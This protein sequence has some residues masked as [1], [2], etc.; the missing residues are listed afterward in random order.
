MLEHVLGR[1][2]W[3]DLHASDLVRYMAARVDLGNPEPIPQIQ[4]FLEL[5]QKKP[6]QDEA[7][8][9]LLRKMTPEARL[10]CADSL[11]IEDYGK[12]LELARKFKKESTSIQERTGY[13]DTEESNLTLSWWIKHEKEITEILELMGEATE[14]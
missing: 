10:P 4:R 13:T 7:V 3:N 5:A 2:L 9:H 14:L 8:L 11:D 1:R 6:P 12:D